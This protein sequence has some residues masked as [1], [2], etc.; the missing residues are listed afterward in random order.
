MN[1]HVNNPTFM[2]VKN[3][4]DGFA[5]ILALAL[6]AF[7]LL[8]LLS[9]S[10]LLRVESSVSQAS[11]QRMHTEQNALLGLYLA[12]GD[13][14]RTVGGDRVITA[15]ADITG[16]E[17]NQYWTG[18]WAPDGTIQEWLVSGEN[19]SPDVALNNAVTLVGP[20]SVSNPLEEVVVNKVTIA[21]LATEAT[22]SAY[23]YYI[24]DEG[25]KE[26]LALYEVLSPDINLGS[27]YVVADQ[28]RRTQQYLNAQTGADRIFNQDFFDL[29]DE[30]SA[31][32]VFSKFSS[33]EDFS[34]IFELDSVQLSERFHDV[35][36]LNL[37]TLTTTHPDSDGR[38]LRTDLTLD[39]N[40]TVPISAYLNA[41]E[42]LS[43]NVLSALRPRSRIIPPVVREPN[44]KT[45]NFMFAPVLSEFMLLFN[46]RLNNNSSTESGRVD[47][48]SPTGFADDL[49]MRVAFA[50]ELWNP[51]N[52]DM[53]V[54]EPGSSGGFTLKIR[55][56]PELSIKYLDPDTGIEYSTYSD[57]VVSL[58][59][60]LA[61]PSDADGAFVVSLPYSNTLE[62]ESSWRSG[63]IV[64]WAGLVCDNGTNGVV[65][66]SNT[67]L[68]ET[69]TS[70][71]H[72]KDEILSDG[73]QSFL[74]GSLM[75]RHLTTYQIPRKETFSETRQGE[76]LT[77]Q[78][79]SSSPIE[80]DLY[81]KDSDGQEFFLATYISPEFQ[82]VNVREH[83]P[84]QLKPNFGYHFILKEPGNGHA[85]WLLGSDIRSSAL[86]EIFEF[87]VLG[88]TPS[89]YNYATITLTQDGNLLE[90]RGGRVSE[91]TASG[92]E[93][94]LYALNPSSDGLEVLPDMDISNDVPLFEVPVD[95]LVSLGSFQHLYIKDS[96]PFSIGNSWVPDTSIGVDGSASLDS[97]NAWFDR[98]YLSGL[99]SSDLDT[100]VTLGSETRFPNPYLRLTGSAL[101]GR[102]LR[103]LYDAAPDDFAQHFMLQG[104]FNINSTSVEAW[105]AI[106]SRNKVQNWSYYNRNRNDEAIEPA[107]IDLRNTF[108]RFGQNAQRSYE[109][110]DSD[111]PIRENSKVYQRGIRSL[112]D[113]QV[114]ALANE[115]VALIRQRAKPYLSLES[116]LTDKIEPGTK[117][118]IEQAIA[119]TVV[120]GEALNE[121]W[122]ETGVEISPIDVNASA[123]LTQADIMTS[124]APY[125]NVRSDT[126]K[127]RSYGETTIG[128]ERLSVQCEATLV[129]LPET[130]NV[131]DAVANPS[132]LGFGRR[133]K[134]VDF[135]WIASSH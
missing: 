94:F 76:L 36:T 93:T 82:A 15:R 126:F 106:L 41:N 56:L 42:A 120:S 107:T 79:S 122:S 44:S 131:E 1:Q 37:Q 22:Q 33:I 4:C 8:L 128:G 25:I 24:A 51:Y 124:L 5:L 74:D 86:P 63:Q 50:C 121:S 31:Y 48:M 14:Q 90:R 43:S 110:V 125:V 49:Q 52:L 117:S 2:P 71:L 11:L 59:D 29:G 105:K 116:F 28:A 80:V 35:T 89:D 99:S 88:D 135:R 32:S 123:Y 66:N 102:S 7:V 113:E 9:V 83:N 47:P 69:F 133:F 13:L 72:H 112:S 27:H 85:D 17:N 23:A 67:A 118:L 18:V 64:N 127:V 87:G 75:L 54:E 108:A 104:G 19:M 100:E 40:L 91:A 57:A 68:K 95:P 55:N 119:N 30:S 103:E 65:L 70:T 53:E 34:N 12:I 115:I 78:A 129:R 81:F 77:M 10:T 21:S 46:F 132:S 38:T 96:P 114:D 60:L 109:V 6:M 26:S 3:S 98:H 130:L 84:F 62:A 58:Q 92:N 45:P 73:A 97:Y 61:A 39:Q 111:L 16:A 20:E 101:D 134:V